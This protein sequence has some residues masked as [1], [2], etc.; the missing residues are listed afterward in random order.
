MWRLTLT[1][2]AFGPGSGSMCF[3][4]W[5][6]IARRRAAGGSAVTLIM[7]ALAWLS[8]RSCCRCAGTWHTSSGKYA[9]RFELPHA[10]HGRSG[11]FSAIL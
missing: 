1:L 5:S 9:S 3:T 2:N 6:S 7:L 11:Y 8:C 10:T 4:T